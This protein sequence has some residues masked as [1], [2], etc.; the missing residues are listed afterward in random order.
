MPTRVSLLAAV[1]ALAPFGCDAGGTTV[2]S[3]VQIGW[4]GAF[5]EMWFVEAPC[6]PADAQPAGVIAP[7]PDGRWIAIAVGEARIPCGARDAVRVYADATDH[8]TIDAP[9]QARVG[10]TFSVRVQAHDRDDGMLHRNGVD[11][12]WEFSGAVEHGRR[13]SCMDPRSNDGDSVLVHAAAPG[14]GIVRVT[15]GEL[16]TEVHVAIVADDTSSP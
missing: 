12:V 15:I 5:D 3:H 16:A 2:L 11:A 14:T 4:T 8:L 10:E 1:L 13:Q 6:R 9:T 7:L